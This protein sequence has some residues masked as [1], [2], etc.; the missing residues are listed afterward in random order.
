[1]NHTNVPYPKGEKTLDSEEACRLWRCPIEHMN[2]HPFEARQGNSDL[3]HIHMQIDGTEV[4]ALGHLAWMGSHG[5][6]HHNEKYTKVDQWLT[7]LGQCCTS[8]AATSPQQWGATA[9][10]CSSA[11]HNLAVPPQLPG[12]GNAGQ[13]DCNSAGACGWKFHQAVHWK[14]RH[15]ENKSGPSQTCPA[16]YMSVPITVAAPKRPFMSR[17]PMMRQSDLALVMA[18]VA[19]AYASSSCTIWS[20][21]DS[22]R[23]D[24]L[25]PPVRNPT[26][27]WARRTV[28]AVIPPPGNNG[29]IRRGYPVTG[30]E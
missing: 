18:T 5:V 22:S 3:G 16:P 26:L 4:A 15:H 27:V 30:T 7:W 17:G 28:W 21:S 8:K 9:E 23:K 13:S 19:L 10:P 29:V 12:E 2:V 6:W 1:M 14:V 24:F 20:S 11:W 25:R